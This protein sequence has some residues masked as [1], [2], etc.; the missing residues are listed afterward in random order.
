MKP[1]EAMGM[2][3]GK[4]IYEQAKNQIN[5]QDAYDVVK[6]IVLDEV[7][8]YGANREGGPMAF[9]PLRDEIKEIV[10]EIYV[11]DKLYNIVVK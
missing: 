5:A 4:K 3:L 6:A 1:E 8:V 11:K 10:K 9:K 2:L 7:G